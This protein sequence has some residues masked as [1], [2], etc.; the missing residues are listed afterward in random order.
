MT[1]PTTVAEGW[2][3]PPASWLDRSPAPPR[4]GSRYRRQPQPATGCSAGVRPTRN[5]HL[6]HYDLMHSW[7]TIRTPEWTPGL[8]ADYQVTD[9]S[10][11]GATSR[12]RVLSWSPTPGRGRGPAALSDLLGIGPEPADAL[13]LSLVTESEL[14]HNP[15][16]KSELEATDSFAMAACCSAVWATDI[17][18]SPGQPRPRGEGPSSP[19]GAGPSHRPALR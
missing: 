4:S 1:D 11:V 6:G 17:T 19:P 7:K 8:V 10:G 15:T 5:M 13:P 3:A 9:R 16:V 12:E 2:P 18:S 14:H